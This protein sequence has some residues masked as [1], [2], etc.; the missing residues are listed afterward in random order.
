MTLEEFKALAPGYV[1]AGAAWLDENE[2]GWEGRI[3]LADLDLANSC[4]CVLGQVM[5]EGDYLDALAR[6]FR[7]SWGDEGT[8]GRADAWAVVRGFNAPLRTLGIG[9]YDPNRWEAY[10]VLDELWI[11]L[12]KERHDSGTLS[13]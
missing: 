13:G 4:R 10:A 3:D 12:V 2:P 11:A 5:P 7:L 9:R 1:A 8:A 6:L